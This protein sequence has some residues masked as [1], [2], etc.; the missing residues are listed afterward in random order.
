MG[1]ENILFFNDALLMIPALFL[2][3][4]FNIDVISVYFLMIACYPSFE[5]KKQLELMNFK[6]ES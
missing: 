6:E 2:I 3:I 1:V 5:A 4:I